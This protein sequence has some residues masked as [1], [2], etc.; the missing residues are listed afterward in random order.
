V[1]CYTQGSALSW[2]WVY[3]APFRGP[4]FDDAGSA[5]TYTF[6]PGDVGTYSVGVSGCSDAAPRTN[7][8]DCT[9]ES[10]QLEAQALTPPVLDSIVCKGNPATVNEGVACSANVTQGSAHSWLWGDQA[11]GRAPYYSN[12]GTAPVV[13]FTPMDTGTYTVSVSACSDDAAPT[14]RASCTSESIQLPVFGGTP[15]GKGLWPPSA[16]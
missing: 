12:L 5:S 2:A 15:E 10:I 3:R 1:I 9:S 7:R 16:S 11:E 14:N 4:A 13:T 8:L 6:T